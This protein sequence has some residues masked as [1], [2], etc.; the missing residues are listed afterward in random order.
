MASVDVDAS[1]LH[2]GASGSIGGDTDIG[3]NVSAGFA[4]AKTS[5]VSARSLIVSLPLAVSLPQAEN[6]LLT[7][8]LSPALGYG[9]LSEPETGGA[10]VTRGASLPMIA[11]GLG[12][13]FAFGLG[14]HAAAH[15]IIIEDSPT[16][17]GFAMSWRF[18]GA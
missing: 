1:L 8:F 10:I 11:A 16:Q 15:R 6:S 17:I 12:F 18:G 7:L 4:K 9:R 2:K 5:D 14:I 3:L 13:Q